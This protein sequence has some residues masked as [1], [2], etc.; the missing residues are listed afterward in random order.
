MCKKLLT[1]SHAISYIANSRSVMHL[2]NQH[3]SEHFP[4]RYCA[5]KGGIIDGD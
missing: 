3:R 2:T 5:Q 4:M 1:L